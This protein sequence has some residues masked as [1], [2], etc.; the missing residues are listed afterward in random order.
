MVL[1][2]VDCEDPPGGRAC[3]EPGQ[4]PMCFIKDGKAQSVCMSL[5][6][7][8]TGDVDR[9]AAA[10][11]AT[12]RALAG[13]A[14]FDDIERNFHLAGGRATFVSANGRVKMTALNPESDRGG[15][16][17]EDHVRGM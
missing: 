8:I 11:K 9:F 1:N 2:C 3:C 7:D 15:G 5:S 14:Y 12:L 6:S 13:P 4:T 16:G 10:L 17:A